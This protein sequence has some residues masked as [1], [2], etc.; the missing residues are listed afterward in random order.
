MSVR[1]KIA[2][3]RPIS[4]GMVPASFGRIILV[5]SAARQSDGT[6]YMNSL[7]AGMRDVLV[8][9]V[10]EDNNGVLVGDELQKKRKE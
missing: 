5:A 10:N 2:A 7:I 6:E 8:T 9:A 1:V 3:S 4:N